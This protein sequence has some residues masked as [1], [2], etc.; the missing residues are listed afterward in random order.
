MSNQGVSWA[1]LPDHVLVEVFSYLDRYS[2]RTRAARTCR[3]WN[4]A[5]RSPYLWSSYNFYF[6]T[7]RQNR[8]LACVEQYGSQLKRVTIELDQR[9]ES[10]RYNACQV[11]KD[12]S[13]QKE[14]RLQYLRVVFT[15]E[16]PCFYAG[17]EFVVALEQ[18]CSPP[19]EESRLVHQLQELDLS[20]LTVAYDDKLFDELSTNH[21]NL[22]KLNIQNTVLVCQVSQ[23]CMI[24]FVQRCRK[25]RDLRIFKYSASEVMLLSFAEEKRVPLEHLSLACRREEKYGKCIS[26]EA[27]ETVCKKLPNLHVTLSFDHTCPLLKVTEVMKPEVPVTVLRLETYMYTHADVRLAT[28]QYKDRLEKLVLTTPMSRARDLTDLNTT[29]LELSGNCPNL[30]ALHVYCVLSADTISQILEQHPKLEHT[31]HSRME[32]FSWQS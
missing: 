12:L 5:F 22:S 9:V 18:L 23:E 8:S 20:G 24:R 17:K 13:K 16:N 27:W 30:K 28:Y 11:I 4:E 26:A 15:G 7:P 21:P 1:D 3:A 19:L 2:D 14:R 25:L 29:L 31:L 32:D 6:Y 10:N